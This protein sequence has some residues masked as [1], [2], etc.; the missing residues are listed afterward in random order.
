MNLK[1]KLGVAILAAVFVP[2]IAIPIAMLVITA[3]V[4]VGL[5]V[6]AGMAALALGIGLVLSE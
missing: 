3:G 5:G 2:V 1:Q 4:W 6:I